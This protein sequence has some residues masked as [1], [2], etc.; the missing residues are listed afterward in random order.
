MAP[1]N[2]I[3]VRTLSKPNE[4][5]QKNSTT[6]HANRG[7]RARPRNAA[8]DGQLTAI[9]A[10]SRPSPASRV[11]TAQSAAKT[12]AVSLARRLNANTAAEAVAL[13]RVPKSY[14]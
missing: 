13:H 7:P 12:A 3:G 14:R 5:S 4:S 8:A 11:L 2:G 9:R 1:P 10:L 6:F